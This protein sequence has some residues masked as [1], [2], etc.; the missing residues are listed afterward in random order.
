MKKRKEY[1]TVV[2]VVNADTDQRE[3]YLKERS[4]DY[5]AMALTTQLMPV[6][7]QGLQKCGAGGGKKR[8]FSITLYGH[9]CF[10]NDSI[11]VIIDRDV[12]TF[13]EEGMQV[14]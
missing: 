4:E 8:I 7:L 5:E 3:L 12:K 9:D 13:I 1:R 14:K 10:H 2:L 11:D 6:V